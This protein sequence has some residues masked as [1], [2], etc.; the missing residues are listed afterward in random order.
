MLATETV[1]QRVPGQSR[2]RLTLAWAWRAA[3]AGL[4]LILAA[5][6]MHGTHLARVARPYLSLAGLSFYVVGLSFSGL[7]FIRPAQGSERLPLLWAW[8]VGILGGLS[9]ASGAAIYVIAAAH[10]LGV[11]L[12]TAGLAIICSSVLVHEAVDSAVSL[13]RTTSRTTTWLLI[14]SFAGFVFL[15]PPFVIFL[16]TNGNSAVLPASRDTGIEVLST[17]L[18]ASIAFLLVGLPEILHRMLSWDRV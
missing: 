16:A 1:V 18:L 10:G 15:F 8:L 3:A 11:A 5:Y 6:V 4:V 17:L 13:S 7:A 2:L 9:V 12:F 14:L